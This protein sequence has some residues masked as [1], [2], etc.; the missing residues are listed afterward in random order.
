MR[1]IGLFLW[2]LLMVLIL[3]LA[4]LAGMDARNVLIG[5]VIGTAAGVAIII[6]QVLD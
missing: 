2:V 1:I 6:Y 4:L 5:A 3:G